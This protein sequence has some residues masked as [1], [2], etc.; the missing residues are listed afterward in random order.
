MA[1][2][3]GILEKG[4]LVVTSKASISIKL[5]LVLGPL[6]PVV[7]SPSEGVEVASLV[8][9]ALG[10]VEGALILKGAKGDLVL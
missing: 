5:A 4:S 2:S 7:N 9:G 3:I 8:V 6:D 10:E 1:Y